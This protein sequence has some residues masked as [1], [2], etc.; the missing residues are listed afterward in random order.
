[1][2]KNLDGGKMK[3]LSMPALIV[4][5]IGYTVVSGCSEKSSKNIQIEP[6]GFVNTEPSAVTRKPAKSKMCALDTINGKKRDNDSWTVKRNSPLTFEGWAFS[7]DGKDAAPQVYVELAG[8]AQTYYAVT[9]DRR[10]RSD[11]NQYHQID[12]KLVVGFTLT[13]QSDAIESGVYE[14]TLHQGFGKSSEYCD[15][16]AT[17][18]IE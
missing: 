5:L 4:S 11:A 3:L 18:T 6:G 15:A 2:E 9:N 16:G 14:I 10:M 13:A 12:A 1:M 17:L 8:P 7:S